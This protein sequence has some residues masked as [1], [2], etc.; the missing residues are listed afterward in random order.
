[1]NGLS[2]VLTLLALLVATAHG[3]GAGGYSGFGSL[4]GYGGGA[5][6]LYPGIVGVPGVGG[7][8]HG[9]GS[10]EQHGFRGGAGFGPVRAVG[11]GYGGALGG[12]YGGYGQYFGAGGYGGAY[13]GGLG[14]AGGLGAFAFPAFGS[15]GIHGGLGGHGG[16]EGKGPHG[17]SVPGVIAEV[18]VSPGTASEI[19]IDNLSG[20]SS[21]KDLAGLGVVVCPSDSVDS[22]YGSAKCE[23][24][25]L[26]CCALHYDTE[27]QSLSVHRG[28]Y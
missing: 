4:L 25:I 12:A 13:G 28:R 24:G 2:T 10:D 22:D 9:H 18:N 21:L 19:N 3:I 26:S 27:D 20:Y 16:H 15:G 1:M 6:P 23:G 11:G 8:S 14:V 5:G 17:D 7:K